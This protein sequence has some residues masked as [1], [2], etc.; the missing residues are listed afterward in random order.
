M[1]IIFS[2]FIPTL[3]KA[4]ARP[5]FRKNGKSYTPK[6]T[7]DAELLIKLAV[8]RQWRQKPVE[9]A[10]SLMLRVYLPRPKSAKKR[11]LPT[12]KPDWDN[13]GKLVSDSLNGLVWKDDAQIVSAFVNKQYCD[14]EQ[15]E[16]GYQITVVRE[17]G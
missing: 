17:G 5:R 8:A 10:V 4:K 3:P 11:E 2:A 9:G 1:S 7:A 16:P 15:P 13:Y 6:N 14:S 12:V